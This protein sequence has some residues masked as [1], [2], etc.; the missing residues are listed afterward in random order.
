LYE[1]K[2]VKVSLNTFTGKLKEDYHTIVEKHA[3]EGGC[4]KFFLRLYM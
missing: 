3:K 1:Y 4:I 2:F